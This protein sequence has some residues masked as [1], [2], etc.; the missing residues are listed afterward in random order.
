[1]FISELASQL[2]VIEN[3]NIGGITSFKKQ[4]KTKYL[5]FEATEKKNPS[6]F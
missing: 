6:I 3:F 5:I 4:N 2:L 1:M